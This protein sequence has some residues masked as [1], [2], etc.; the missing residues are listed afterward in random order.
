MLLDLNSVTIF[1]T[2]DIAVIETAN[3]IILCVIK[4]STEFYIP[5]QLIY[6][7]RWTACYHKIKHINYSSL[8]RDKA[9]L[10]I[11]SA[12]WGHLNK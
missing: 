9:T 4:M 7:M 2:Q 1:Q 12:F 11:R 5:F 3:I 10:T 8:S 6:D